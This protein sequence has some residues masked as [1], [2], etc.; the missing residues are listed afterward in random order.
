MTEAGLSLAQRRVLPGDY[1]GRLF[2]L[3]QFKKLC[4]ILRILIYQAFAWI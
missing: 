1:R 4:V 2:I 3:L